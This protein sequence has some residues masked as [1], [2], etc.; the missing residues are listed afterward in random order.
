MK[1]NRMLSLG[2][3]LSFLCQQGSS[4]NSLSSP[5]G[6]TC[7]GYIRVSYWGLRDA[8]LHIGQG[9]TLTCG[10]LKTPLA[11]RDKPVAPAILA[12]P[13]AEVA[14]SMGFPGLTGI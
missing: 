14:V 11:P 8:E 6:K 2:A 1:A 10:L 12:F 13:N 9:P 5:D 7:R 3:W 4:G